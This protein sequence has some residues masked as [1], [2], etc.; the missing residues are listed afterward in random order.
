MILVASAVYRPL[1]NVKL[2]NSALS[3]KRELRRVSFKIYISIFTLC[4][5]FSFEIVLT[6][7]NKLNDFRVSRDSYVTVRIHSLIN[8]DLGGA[9]V[10]LK[11]PICP[12]MLFITK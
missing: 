1:Q 9:V 12:I 3:G 7:R 5:I 11:L 6:K 4:S 8:I 10:A 2:P